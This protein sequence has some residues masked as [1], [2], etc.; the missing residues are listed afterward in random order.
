MLN[1][2]NDLRSVRCLVERLLVAVFGLLN[3]SKEDNFSRSRFLSNI[4][5]R[6]PYD[7]FI[8]Y[9]VISE[10]TAT[11]KKHLRYPWTKIS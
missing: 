11:G 2:L 8:S 9:V 7:M 5:H 10:L 1:D 3:I 4:R 6:L